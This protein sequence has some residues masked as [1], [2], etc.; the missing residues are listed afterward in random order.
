MK[1]SVEDRDLLLSG[2]D[3]EQR[4]FLI[5]GMTRSRRTHFANVLAR[6]KGA[7]IPQGATYE[8]IE[9]LLDEWIYIG[10]IDA[11]AVTPELRCECGRPLRYQH[12]VKHKMSNKVLKFGINHLEEHMG[13]DAKIVQEIINGF[14][15][16]DTELD[17]ILIK[18][19]N[20]W[21]NEN[22]LPPEA[23]FILLPNELH[24]HIDLKLPL[25]DSQIVRIR[26]LINQTLFN[27]PPKRPQIQYS[28]AATKKTKEPEY[29]E[30]DLFTQVESE[31][32]PAA[33]N[34]LSATV[35]SAVH[36]LLKQGVGS[37]RIICERLIA[38]TNVP[39]ER[40]LTGKPI[41]YYEVCLHIEEYIHQG[42]CQMVESSQ[43]DRKYKWLQ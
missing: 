22:V 24:R 4:Q 20:G 17:E 33:S 38:D 23:G 34:N 31:D 2:L 5:G 26:S 14:E 16:I 9:A 28:P 37:A 19:R 35:C 36:N 6:Q 15:A 43:A 1:L 42:Y 40:F 21:S 7:A 25:L 12:Q 30:W 3:F 18:Y 10:Y 11:G 27:T 41:I 13:I 29:V 32:T 8:D 39:D